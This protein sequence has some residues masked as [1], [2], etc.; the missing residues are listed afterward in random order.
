MDHSLTAN[1]YMSHQCS[2]V[3]KGLIKSF[4]LLLNRSMKIQMKKYVLINANRKKNYIFAKSNFQFPKTFIFATRKLAKFKQ[5]NL[6]LYVSGSRAINLWSKHF[7]F[8]KMPFSLNVIF[9][10]WTKISSVWK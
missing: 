4:V 10:V 1:K 6:K 9:G 7:I 8:F 5:T 2:M 3:A